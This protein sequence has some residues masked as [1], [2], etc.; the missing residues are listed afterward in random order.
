MLCDR[1]LKEITVKNKMIDA[2]VYWDIGRYPDG[3][4]HGSVCEKCYPDIREENKI[5][6]DYLEWESYQ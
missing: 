2:Y 5:M 4:R 1:C 6:N 3:C